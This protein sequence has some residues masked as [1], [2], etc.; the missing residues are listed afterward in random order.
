MA[1]YF[2]KKRLGQHFLTSE[3]IVSR[4]VDLISPKAEQTILEVGPGRGVLTLPLA[5]SGANLWAIEFDR[6]L[7]G[8]LERLLGP[9]KNATLINKDFLAFH[10]EDYELQSFMLVGNLP[11][12]ITSP[13][14]DWCIRYYDRIQMA[15]FM[16]QREMAW[17][18]T[19]SPGSKDWSPIG[20]FTQLHFDAT[21]CFDVPQHAF[22]PPPE[23]VSAVI[24]LE[25]WPTIPKFNIEKLEKVVR[26]S[27]TQRRKTL[28]NNLVPNL[29]ADSTKLKIILAQ[30]D[31]TE[32]CRAEELSIAQFA[33]LSE[34][35]IPSSPGAHE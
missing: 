7:I 19:G 32:N 31:L 24:K 35:L 9:Y 5:E 11:Y 34:I 28:I 20:I 4:M 16:V 23:V 8:T 13:I 18:I 12:N 22:T 17:R 6:D 3:K 10:P 2:A 27:F 26:A 21:Y 29:I 25:P 30:L 15:V 33:R 14:I 1:A